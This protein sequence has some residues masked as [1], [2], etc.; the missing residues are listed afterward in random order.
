MRRRLWII[1][2]FALVAFIGCERRPLNPTYKATVRTIVKC[3]WQV[4]VQAYPNGEKPTGVTLFFFRNGKFYN[5]VTTSNIDSCEVQ[6][7]VGKY[8][9]YMISQSPDEYWKMEFNNMTSF[10]NASA[11]LR[12]SSA[13]WALRSDVDDPVVENPEILFAGVSDEF[14]ITLEMTEDYQYYYTN[15]KK[16]MSSKGNTR[17]DE[18]AEMEEMVRYYTIRVPI[19]PHNIVSQLWFRIYTG[20][21]DVLKSVRATTSG[22]ARTFELTQ[23]TTGS[24]EAVQMITD[25]SVTTDNVGTR[26]GHVDGIITTFGLPNGETPS[27]MRDSSLNVSA[28]LI[29]NATVA[30][31]TFN[32]GDKIQKLAPNPGYR[33][34]YKVVFGS[35]ENPAITPPDVR[36]P[37][38]GGFAAVVYD[39][40]EII[41]ASLLL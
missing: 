1:L 23:N 13:K 41:E 35:V 19:T 24:E 9:M 36:P 32:V 40:D 20:N 38:G 29:D 39:W 3:I 33:A 7:P 26:V 4:D 5:S 6:L 28:L 30:N 10:Q 27:A 2:L 34:L 16:K 18:I 25:W 31:Y 21:V 14:E 17:A 11:S 15:L 8:K 22:M 37:D 12:R